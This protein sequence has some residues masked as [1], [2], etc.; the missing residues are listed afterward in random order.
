MVV[1]ANLNFP[2]SESSTLSSQGV[3]ICTSSNPYKSN[4]NYKSFNCNAPIS[5]GLSFTNYQSQ[6]MTITVSN[7]LSNASINVY[8]NGVFY[9]TVPNTS[10]S[11]TP[12]T[13]SFLMSSS[14]SQTV[15]YF[16]SYVF[17]IGFQRFYPDENT[18]Y[19]TTDTYEFYCPITYT[20]SSTVSPLV[21]ISN[22]S[23]SY[24]IDCNTTVSLSSFSNFNYIG[25]SSDT[26]G[27]APYS[28]ID[29]PPSYADV[30]NGTV[31]NSYYPTLLWSLWQGF[32]QIAVLYCTKIY[33]SYGDLV[34][35]QQTNSLNNQRDQQI[36][37]ITNDASNGQLISKIYASTLGSSLNFFNNPSFASNFIFQNGIVNCNSGSKIGLLGTSIKSLVCFFHIFGSSTSYNRTGNQMVLPNIYSNVDKLIIFIQP[38]YGGPEEFSVTIS[39]IITTVSSTIVTYNVRRLD[40]TTGW[41]SSLNLGVFVL[42]LS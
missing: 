26:L 2:F 20:V 14:S 18:N 11:S 29:Y 28:L 16:N 22:F 10:Y 9:Y 7:V 40:S 13:K 3:L 42:E 30:W 21:Y 23:I 31:E 38:Y 19:G 8:K 35:K 33:I 41:S 36:Q 17:N 27:Y 24:L 37:W 39:N 32:I 1:T 12:I 6:P 5:I 34:F 15:F 4:N 25:F